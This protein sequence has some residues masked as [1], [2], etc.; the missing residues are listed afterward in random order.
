[1]SLRVV[2][3]DRPWGRRWQH[4]NLRGSRLVGPVAGEL[5]DLAWIRVADSAE[6]IIVP[7][8]RKPELPTILVDGYHSLLGVDDA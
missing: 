4:L 8:R 3:A 7:V 6:Q 1:V 2:A 5:F